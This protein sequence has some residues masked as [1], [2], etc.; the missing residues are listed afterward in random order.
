HGVLV[1]V[2]A[3]FMQKAGEYRFVIQAYDNHA[4]LHKDH[5]VKPALEMNSIFVDL[6]IVYLKSK[7]GNWHVSWIRKPNSVNKFTKFLSQPE[8]KA[9]VNWV[10]KVEKGQIR[11]AI[12]G[13]FFEKNSGRMI[14]ECGDGKAG[15]WKRDIRTNIQR[16]CFGMKKSETKY[17]I[18]RMIKRKI[19]NQ[20][21]YE[22]D[23]RIEKNYEYGLSNVGILILKGQSKKPEDSGSWPAHNASVSRTVIGFSTEPCHIFFIVAREATWDDVVKFLKGLEEKEK[24]EGKE[25]LNDLVKSSSYGK[26]LNI[27]IIDALML[28]G[29]GSTQFAYIYKNMKDEIRIKDDNAPKSDGRKI[30][31]YVGA[32]A[33]TP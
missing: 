30:P 3:S 1:R 20:I 10:D 23:P 24:K 14:G 17:E 11:T 25:D 32:F 12:N 16:W 4:H 6:P 13:N 27:Q 26:N 8:S 28:D 15:I 29:G 19:R 18:S 7:D 2:P 21:Y 5:Q 22:V 31:N 33:I 9:A